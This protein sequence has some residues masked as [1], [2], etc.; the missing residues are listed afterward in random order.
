MLLRRPADGHLVDVEV[1][2]IDH[3]IDEYLS[4]SLSNDPSRIYNVVAVSYGDD[5]EF[6][7]KDDASIE[8][9]GRTELSL[10]LPLGPEQ[11]AWAEYLAKAY[12]ADFKDP[13]TIV[14]LSIKADYAIEIGDMVFVAQTERAHLFK[15]GQV[16]EIRQTLS[17]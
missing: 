8:A 2:F 12:L 11:T 9:Y 5:Q 15:V 7:A 10:T 13:K 16:A 17:G 1:V 14:S 4:L 3:I 6:T